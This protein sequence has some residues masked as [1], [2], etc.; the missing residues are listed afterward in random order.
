MW[1]RPAL[2]AARRNW[3]NFWSAIL[4]SFGT[5]LRALLFGAAQVSS[6][7]PDDRVAIEPGL[8]CVPRSGSNLQDGADVVIDVRGAS[9]WVNCGIHVMKTVGS[10]I[11]TG[12]EASKFMFSFLFPYQVHELLPQN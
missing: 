3:P 9:S 12:L 1:Q 7:K 8:P 5:N 2:L 4:S 11:P 10:V 6:L